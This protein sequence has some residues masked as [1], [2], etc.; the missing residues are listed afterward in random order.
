MKPND[1]AN[2]QHFFQVLDHIYHMHFLETDDNSIGK[3]YCFLSQKNK[4]KRGVHPL[5]KANG[6]RM[7][8]IW[9]VFGKNLLEILKIEK[10]CI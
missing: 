9:K 7:C 6:K 1:H 5:Y 3:N 10:T 8:Q 4:K 2:K